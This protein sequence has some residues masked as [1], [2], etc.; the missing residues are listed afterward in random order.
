MATP[1]IN[2][3]LQMVLNLA[4]NQV[5]PAAFIANY[6]F[7]DPTL[8]CT[9]TLYEPFLQAVNTGLGTVVQLPVATCYAVVVQNL[10]Q[11][12][13]SMQVNWTPSGTPGTACLLGPGGVFAYIDPTKMGSGIT[14]L[15]IE[16]VGG[17]VPAFVF[18]GG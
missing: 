12:G 4:N 18:V 10:S 9:A 16:G 7:S 8:G 3:I 15:S 13:A 2:A 5:S 14:A 17:T 6:D 11:T 1:N